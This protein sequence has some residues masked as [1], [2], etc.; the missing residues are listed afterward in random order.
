M[1]QIPDDLFVT[2]IFINK[3]VKRNFVVLSFVVYWSWGKIG[4]EMSYFAI[5]EEISFLRGSVYKG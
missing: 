2:R 4:V 5:F 3:R 1:F